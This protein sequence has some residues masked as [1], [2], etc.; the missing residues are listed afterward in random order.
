MVGQFM[1][2]IISDFNCIITVRTTSI[3][4]RL[5]Y[6]MNSCQIIFVLITFLENVICI[7]QDDFYAYGYKNGDTRAPTNDDGSTSPIPVG[8]LF[9]FFNRQHQ[10]LIVSIQSYSNVDI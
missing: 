4:G 1:K 6:S 2:L 5:K 3:Y 9:P 8:S 10:S 7:S